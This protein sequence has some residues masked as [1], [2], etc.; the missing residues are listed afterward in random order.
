MSTTI[1]DQ[2]INVSLTSF[3]DFVLKSGLPKV[4]CAQSI[5]RQIAEGYHPGRDYYKSFRD[6]LTKAHSKNDSIFDSLEAMMTRVDKSRKANYQLLTRGYLKF[7]S[8]YLEPNALA[9]R[10][11]IAGMWKYRK[12]CVRVNPELAFSDGMSNYLVKL[13]CKDE[14]LSKPQVNIILHTMQMAVRQDVSRPV[15]A[16]L[17]VRRSRI[18]E[19]TSFNPKW[20]VL[21]EGEALAFARMYSADIDTDDFAE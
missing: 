11:P 21:L 3:A 6:T 2:S 1:Q 8:S 19:S 13:Y 16:I 20:T 14:A 7:W 4:T 15:C 18:F 9:W 17:D 5:R 10:T 12:V